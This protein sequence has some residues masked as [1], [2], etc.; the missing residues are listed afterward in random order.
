M[1]RVLSAHYRLPLLVAAGLHVV[2]IVLLSLRFSPTHYRLPGPA[3]SARPIEAK[4]VDAKVLQRRLNTIARQAREHQEALIRAKRRH[5]EAIARRLA[6]I[7]A[8]KALVKQRQLE[9]ARVLAARQKAAI[10]AKKRLMLKQKHQAAL[11][12]EQKRLQAVMAKKQL[13]LEQSRLAALEAQRLAGVIDRYKAAVIAAIQHS[14]YVPQGAP[15][16][17]LCR[18][19]IRLAPGGSVLAVQLLKSSGSKALD[20]SARAAIYKASPLPVPKDSA[21]FDRFRELHLTV[22]PQAS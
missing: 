5:Q 15:R 22:S 4:V 16:A 19:D 7:K 11:L 6:R 3:T 10:Q 2:L 9:K 17:A 21:L 14:W 13:A 8:H 20:Q 1:N 18:F 12:A